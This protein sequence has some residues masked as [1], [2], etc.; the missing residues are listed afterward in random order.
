MAET[1]L[2]YDRDGAGIELWPEALRSGDRIHVAFRAARVVGAMSVP[3]YEVTVLDARCRRVA[4]LLRGR[5]RPAGGVICVDWDGRD[6]GGAWVPP[7]LYRL[8]V[9]SVGSGLRLERTI[10]VEP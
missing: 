9:E 6:D 5:A 1:Y 7:G 2:D 10:Y 3:H 8:R 4:T